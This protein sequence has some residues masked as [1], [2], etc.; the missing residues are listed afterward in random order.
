MS[1]IRICDRCKKGTEFHASVKYY[2]GQIK[3]KDHSLLA[4]N[5]VDLCEKCIDDF[6]KFLGEDKGI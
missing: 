6:I 2:G 1:R 4:G 3:V 5:I